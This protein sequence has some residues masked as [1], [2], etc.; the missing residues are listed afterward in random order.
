[1]IM[2]SK[3]EVDNFRHTNKA[4]RWGQQ[5]YQKFKLDKVTNPQDKDFCDRL[6]NATEEKAKAMV[7]S[8]TDKSQ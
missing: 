3:S 4:L 2:F 7:A 8:R 5:F 1:M 6:Y